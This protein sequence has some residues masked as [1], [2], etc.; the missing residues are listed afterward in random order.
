MTMTKTALIAM[1]VFGCTSWVLAEDAAAP[2]APTAMVRFVASRHFPAVFVKLEG[3]D[4]E[5]KLIDDH[6]TPYGRLHADLLYNRVYQV[7]F[8]STGDPYS[9]AKSGDRMVRIQTIGSN[10]KEG[11][12][13]APEPA[14]ILAMPVPSTPFYVRAPLSVPGV[15]L[16]AANSMA[17]FNNSSTQWGVTGGAHS[18]YVKPAE[19]NASGLYS[20]ST[21][22]IKF[23]HN[24][25]IVL[26]DKTI[27]PTVSIITPKNGQ[28]VSGTITVTAD[29]TK[30]IGIRAMEFLVDGLDHGYTSDMAAPRPYR[31]SIDTTKLSNGPH[32]IVAKAYCSSAVNVLS[33]KVTVKVQNTPP[34]GASTRQSTN[35]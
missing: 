12:L 5:S 13:P 19:K 22:Y 16:A 1:I 25:D 15:S 31:K 27:Q 2:P 29:I 30:G 21:L 33:E 3:Q 34:T 8:E 9:F 10:G 14:M 6:G 4:Q 23:F 18:Y 7:R 17:D 32:A 28:T 11:K 24:I 20:N 35:K 26:E